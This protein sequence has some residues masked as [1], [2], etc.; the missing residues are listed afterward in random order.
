MDSQIVKLQNVIMQYDADVNIRY[1]TNLMHTSSRNS[2]VN[3]IYDIENKCHIIPKYDVIDFASYFNCLQVDNWKTKT[4][5]IS[6]KLKLEFKGKGIVEFT[7]YYRNSKN[8]NRNV[9][10]EKVVESDKKTEV[11]IDIPESS[12]VLISFSITA[13]EDFSIYTASYLAEVPKDKIKKVKI[14]LASTTFKKEALLRRICN[15]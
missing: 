9:L 4:Y 12:K 7:E 8:I 15:Y 10:L 6:F 5:A 3:M 14:S 11:V 13:L 2:R 1:Y